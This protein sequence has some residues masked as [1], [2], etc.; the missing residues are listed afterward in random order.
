MSA[1]RQ[2]QRGF[3]LIE[4]MIVIGIIGIIAAVS[5]P[6]FV[7]GMRREGMRKATGD[8]IEACSHARAAAILG[9]KTAELVINPQ[10]K[11]FSVSAGG[12]QNFSSAFPEN[13][14]IEMLD[15]NFIELKDSEQDVKLR[16]YANSTSPEFTMI[17]RS[18]EGEV[19]KISLDVVTGLADMEMM[20]K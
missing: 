5:I 1:R 9:D 10:A 19:C 13:I 7:Q 11:S 12:Q 6:S 18:D 2:L 17:L 20:N 14:H 3:T 15:I 8:F 4:I 16:F